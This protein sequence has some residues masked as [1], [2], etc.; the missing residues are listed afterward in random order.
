MYF[1]VVVSAPIADRRAAYHGARS[2]EN[3][4]GQPLEFLDLKK[5]LEE[6]PGVIVPLVT[7]SV[8][9]AVVQ[10]LE[11]HGIEAEITVHSEIR[12]PEMPDTGR[13]FQEALGRVSGFI[14]G[15]PG[16]TCCCGPC[17]RGRRAF[18]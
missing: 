11:Y 12:E 2:L 5:E 10:R 15:R 4:D 6:A 9:T 18:R 17:R 7:R 8:A 3:V 16:T 13:R 1:D 14:R